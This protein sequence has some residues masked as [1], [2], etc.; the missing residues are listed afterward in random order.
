MIVQLIFSLTL[1]NQ[2]NVIHLNITTLTPR[3]EDIIINHVLYPYSPISSLLIESGYLWV[4]IDYPDQELDKIGQWLDG[5]SV[6]HNAPDLWMEADLS[7]EKDFLGSYLG[8]EYIEQDDY[9]FVPT[10]SE[11]EITF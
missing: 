7:L 2:D 5:I 4:Y 11:V 10:L 3:M 1:Q 9:E 6:E 8:H